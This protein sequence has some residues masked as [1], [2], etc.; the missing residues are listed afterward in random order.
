M[1]DNWYCYVIYVIFQCAEI[2]NIYKNK[3]VTDR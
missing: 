2:W 3:E 1:L